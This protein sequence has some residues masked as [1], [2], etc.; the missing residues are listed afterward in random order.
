MKSIRELYRTGTG[1]SSSHTMALVRAAEIFLQDTSDASAYRVT[2][3][4]SL[5]ATG[6]GHLSDQ[7]LYDAFAGKAL[8]LVWRPEEV[9]PWHP[10]GMLFEALQASGEVVKS[11]EVC[12]LGG[13]ALGAPD[14]EEQSADV[15]GLISMAEILQHC[16]RTGG[17]L[18]SY[19]QASE[20]EGIMDFLDGVWETMSQ[21]VERGLSR[22]GALPG[23][24]GLSRKA[25]SFYRNASLFGQH[26]QQD[27]L[28][29]AYAHAVAEENAC[30]GVIVTAPTCGASGVLPALLRYLN[31]TLDCAR[32]DILRALGVAGLVGNLVKH[33][34]SI[35]GAEVGCQGEI[36]TACAMAAAA[37]VKLHGG[38]L[39]QI[40][41]AAE[42]GLEHH[43][44]LTC[45][46][47]LGLVQIPC[48]ERNAHAATRALS[49]CHF[50][51]LTDGRH[52]VPF[53]EIVAVMKET[54]QALPS[55]Y[56][57]TSGAGIAEAYRR[58]TKR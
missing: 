6:R 25:R 10:N 42:M 40:E 5:A 24:L 7:A 31:E 34:A 57:E 14:Y 11:W 58:R 13:G 55:L 20:G 2:L 27:G 53:D 17:S 29:C 15:Y 49:C 50:S 28:L 52:K 18:W 39:Q 41:Y 56:R 3:F 44:G 23:S 37:A 21:A 36:G 32:D 35:S 51:L 19:V 48:I 8:E 45:D 12:S 43:L 16:D 26:F 22:E 4:G 9:L 47:V 30:G 54:G 46:P 38:S 33:N 1:P